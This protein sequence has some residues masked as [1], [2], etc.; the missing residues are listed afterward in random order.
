MKTKELDSFM[1]EKV[2]ALLEAPNCYKDLRVA[3]EVWQKAAGT[4][5]EAEA[6]AALICELEAD[7]LT[8][9]QMIE[10]VGSD[11]GKKKFG[12]EKAAKYVAH[13]RDLKA[14]GEKYCFCKACQTG[15]QILERKAELI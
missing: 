9:D 6:T 13:A 12:K 2:S 3:A 10:I 5:K 4:E 7:V 14:K 1:K 11:F 15:H 8:I